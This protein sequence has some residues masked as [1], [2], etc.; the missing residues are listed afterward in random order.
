MQVVCTNHPCSGEDVQVFL[1]DQINTLR[2]SFARVKSSN[3]K[4]FEMLV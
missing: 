1:M 3:D 2:D 4:A